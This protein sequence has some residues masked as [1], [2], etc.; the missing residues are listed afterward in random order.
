MKSIVLAAAIMLGLAGGAY[1]QNLPPEYKWEVGLNGGYSVITRPTGP[2]DVYTGRSTNIVKDISLRATYYINWRWMLSLDISD[3]KWE[4]FGQWDLNGRF[5]QKLAPV[6]VNFLIADHALMQNVQIN[7]VIPFYTRYRSYNKANVYFGA[8]VGLVQTVND[9][10]RG[11]TKYPTDIDSS[12]KYVSS[13]HYSA[14]TGYSVGAQAGFI[15]YIV[16]RLGVTAELSMRYVD[17]RT[18]DQN[19]AAVMQRYHLLHF[20]QTVGVRWRF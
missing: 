2:P 18:T 11:Y 13:V 14:G 9:G 20:P 6:K 1:A 12:N 8:H 15:Y 4:S 17:V 3:R 7:H 5:N 19:A 16:P 10:S